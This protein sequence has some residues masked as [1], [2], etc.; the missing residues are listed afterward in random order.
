MVAVSSED[1]FFICGQ[2]SKY[3]FDFYLIYRLEM[4]SF[5]KIFRITSSKTASLKL[6]VL[7]LLSCEFL[8]VLG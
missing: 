1:P 7:S 5:S 2:Y 3:K 4:A 8:G 6:P